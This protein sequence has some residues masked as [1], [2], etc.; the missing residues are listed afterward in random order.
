MSR[1]KGSGNRGVPVSMRDEELFRSAYARYYR[2][3]LAYALRRTA[4][5][6]DAEDVHILHIGKSVSRIGIGEHISWRRT[7]PGHGQHR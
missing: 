5:C 7:A 1:S 6:V 3:V 2:S 4:S